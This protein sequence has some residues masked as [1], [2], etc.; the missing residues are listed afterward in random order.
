LLV[1]IVSKN[2]NKLLSVPL[3]ADGTPDE[4]EL[5]ILRE[6]GAWMK[7]NSESIV[8][9]RPWK[10]FGEGPIAE[11]D[12]KINAQGF[13]DGYY[14]KAGADE[15]RFT[16]TDMYLYVSALAWPENHTVSIS[17][18]AE[19]SSFFPQKISCV[20]LLCYGKVNCRTGNA[21]IV[22]LPEKPLNKI[23]PVQRIKK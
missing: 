11:S 12:I 13:N 18:L 9:T 10:R 5:A 8:K 14:T 16:Q 6:F 19:D 15:I 20:E 17:S 2:G 23:M 3:R 1:D 4:K 21:L 7:I 22:T